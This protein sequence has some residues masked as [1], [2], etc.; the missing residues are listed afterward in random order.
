MFEE[1]G[2]CCALCGKHQSELKKAL[3]VDHDHKTGRVRKLLCAKCNLASGA[4]DDD[5][6]LL[7]AC[8]EYLEGCEENH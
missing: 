3:H 5:I 6:G 7:S 8:I 4:F 1:Q 2:G